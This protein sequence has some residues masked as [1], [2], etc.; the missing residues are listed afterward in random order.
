[1][2]FYF[3]GFPPIP[4]HKATGAEQGFVAALEAANKLASADADEAPDEEEEEEKEEEVG[5]ST[6]RSLL[7]A[8]C[9]LVFVNSVL[10]VCVSQSKAAAP[11]EP[12]K[13]LLDVSAAAQ[14]QKRTPSSSPER[15]AAREGLSATG[16]AADN[17]ALIANKSLRHFQAQTTKVLRLQLLKIFAPQL[18]RITFEF[19]SVFIIIIQRFSSWSSWRVGRS[20]T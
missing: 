1:M 16:R 7:S 5:D 10:C 20:S 9:A 2:F 13:L 6:V 14:G 11:E 19:L 12:K 17:T 3:T 4:G 15:S 8:F 18:H